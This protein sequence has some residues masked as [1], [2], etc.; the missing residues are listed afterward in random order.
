MIWL[1]K[2]DFHVWN[3]TRHWVLSTKPWW[4]CINENMELRNTACSFSWW[5]NG[6]T[7]C[8]Q[9]LS[10]SV[11][12][13]KKHD[14]Y[15][16]L[17]TSLRIKYWCMIA[18]MNEMSS[19]IRLLSLNTEEMQANSYYWD[20]LVYRNINNKCETNEKLYQYFLFLVKHT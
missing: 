8:F 17:C 19:I 13:I 20:S 11:F 9:H 5:A 1:M 16:D 4:F 6:H 10:V 18:S 7:A 15:M 3:K 2:A 12:Q 14:N